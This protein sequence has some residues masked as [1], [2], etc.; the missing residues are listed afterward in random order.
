MISRK[1]TEITLGLLSTKKVN[2][3]R[4]ASGLTQTNNFLV[5][6]HNKFS[7]SPL[8]KLLPTDFHYTMP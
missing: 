1:Q 3:I 4:L 2:K 5:I 7:F 8:Q 6:S